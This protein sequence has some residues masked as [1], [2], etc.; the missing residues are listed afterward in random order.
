[1][2][3]PKPGQRRLSIA[4]V[5]GVAA[6]LFVVGAIVTRNNGGPGS[7]Q[8]S[9]AEI[10]KAVAT[11][12]AAAR[13]AHPATARGV[14]PTGWPAYVTSVR[15]IG[16]DRQ[17]ALDAMGT[18]G[19]ASDNPPVI[20]VEISGTFGSGRA[21]GPS[22][23]AIASI[24]GSYLQLALDPHSGQAYDSGIVGYAMDLEWYSTP[25]TIYPVPASG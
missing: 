20:L 16:T 14:S 2:N 13:E 7:W 4:A 12:Q 8:P 10:Q 5:V 17:A 19:A 11:A 22:N 23:A 6:L 1:V 15:L 21:F 24:H 25:I 18:P 9:G 3:P